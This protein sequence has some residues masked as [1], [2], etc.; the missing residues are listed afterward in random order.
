MT[1]LSSVCFVHPHPNLGH[2]ESAEGA[3]LPCTGQGEGLFKYMRE[4]GALE[5]NS[6]S[7]CHFLFCTQLI[8][9]HLI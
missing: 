4:A 3:G 2:G 1:R 8:L 5:S 7:Q 6:G 9:L